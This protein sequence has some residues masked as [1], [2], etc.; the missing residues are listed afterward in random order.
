M[1]Q[2]PRNPKEEAVRLLDMHSEIKYGSDMAAIIRNVYPGAKEHAR[3]T[4]LDIIKALEIT[5]GH[6]TLS[7]QDRTEVR[8]DIDYWIDVEREI[9]KL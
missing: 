6:C 4:V 8:R 9:H 3:A 2:S 7:D 1:S 5:T